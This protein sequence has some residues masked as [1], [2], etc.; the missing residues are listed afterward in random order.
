M[1]SSILK[2]RGL[3][4]DTKLKISFSPFDELIKSLEDYSCDVGF[5]MLRNIDTIPASFNAAPISEDRLSL[6]SVFDMDFSNLPELLKDN[7]LFLLKG[8]ARWTKQITGLL[9]EMNIT[10]FIRWEND[11]SDMLS[12]VLTGDGISVLPHSEVLAER[13][14]R[15]DLKYLDFQGEKAMIN[16]CAIWH[17]ENYNTCILPL[18][19][20][21]RGTNSKSTSQEFSP[22]SPIILAD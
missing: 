20:F 18:I 22:D 21:I 2:L 12:R 14:S 1:N 9:H 10:P 17:K 6:V 19:N 7:P 4:P 15:T 5:A 8:D 11:F 16:L 13:K 3:F